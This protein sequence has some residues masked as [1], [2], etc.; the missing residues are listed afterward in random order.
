MGGVLCRRLDHYILSLVD[1][2]TA[3]PPLSL[4][5]LDL[6]FL[7]RHDGTFHHLSPQHLDRY[8]SEF[9]G[10]HNIRNADTIDMM[11][12]IA[13]EMVGRRLRY[14]ELVAD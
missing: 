6:A 1:I 5:S 13:K 11:A 8:V 9:S 10:R 12:F 4:K 7:T 2:S 14:R 3:K